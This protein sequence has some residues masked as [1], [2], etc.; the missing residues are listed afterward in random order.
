MVCGVWCVVCGVWCVV[1]GVWCMVYGVWCVVCGVWC[2]VCGVWR[3]VHGFGVYP[4]SHVHSY[5]PS[6]LLQVASSWQGCVA[7]IEV[8][9][10]CVRACVREKVRVCVC[11]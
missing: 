6:V 7:C 10:Q 9:P 1:C 2:M 5:D 3:E 8:N 4:S 11:M